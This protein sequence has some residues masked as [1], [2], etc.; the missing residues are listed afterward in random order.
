MKT[1]SEEKIEKATQLLLEGLGE[2]LTRAGLKDT[3]KRVAKA[4]AEWCRGYLEL[5]R[6]LVTFES[7][8]LEMVIRKGIPFTSFCEHHLAM[9]QGT[10]DLAFIP[11]G[12][13]VGLSK[14]I[15]FVQHCAA[16]LTIQE[17][18]TNDIL[19]RFCQI[20]KPKG[21]V[22]KISAFHS[23][24][25][26]RGTKVPNVPTITIASQGIFQQKPELV[27]QFNDLIRN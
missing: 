15:R 12:Q 23:C 11:N 24:E 17:N 13:V 2:D 8:Y 6:P 20:V 19:N 9:Y 16:R 22:V 3:P 10:V 5:N 7:S 27:N 26:T 18:L 1:I 25:G 4:W 14:I 21:L